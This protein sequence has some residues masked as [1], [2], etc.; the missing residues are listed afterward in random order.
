MP[1]GRLLRVFITGASSGIGAALARHYAH[2][3]ATLGLVA[4]REDLLTRL[5]AELNVPCT[6]HAADVRDS[7][8]LARAAHDFIAAHGTPDVVI[9]NAGVSRGTLTRHAEDTTV[10]RDILDV[11]VL[12]IV[13]TFQPFMEPL[14]RNGGGT[15]VGIASVAGFR[16]IP[17]TGAY[18]ASKAAAITYLESLRVELRE[19]GIRVITI[20]PGYIATPMTERNPFPM[21]FIIDADTAATKIARVIRRSKPF[22]IIPWQMAIVGRLYRL[23]PRFV[24]DRIFSRT[25]RKPRGADRSSGDSA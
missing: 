6:V 24:F 25:P 14:T 21:P 18:A 19:S 7:T 9:A 23:L 17:G 16:G 13:N 11:N 12:G 8:A 20:C 10:F 15:L 22:A 1:S 3:G 2:K 5:A 4:R